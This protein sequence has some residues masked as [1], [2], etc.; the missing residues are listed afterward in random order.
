MEEKDRIENLVGNIKAYVETRIDLVLLNAQ[1]KL[2]DILS[3]IAVVVVLALF[4]VFAVL[5]L[6]LGAA[7]WINQRLDNSFIGFFCIAGFYILLAI[8][9]YVIKDKYIRL[10][11]INSLLKKINLNEDDK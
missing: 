3:S 9:V 2:T 7:W 5:F 6:S 8:I 4:S 11:I 10:P 1:D